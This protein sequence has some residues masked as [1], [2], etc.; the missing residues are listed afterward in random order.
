MGFSFCHYLLAIFLTLDR[1]N[2]TAGPGSQI[3]VE[4]GIFTKATCIAQE[5]ISLVIVNGPE[6]RKNTEG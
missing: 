5:W 6:V 4:L 2:S 3:V 1:I